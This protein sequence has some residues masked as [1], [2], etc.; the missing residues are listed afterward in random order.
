MHIQSLQSCGYH[1]CEE[2]ER[3]RR[4]FLLYREKVLSDLKWVAG[5][6]SNHTLSPLCGSTPMSDN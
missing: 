2:V 5:Y 6:A 4:V 1:F 3:L